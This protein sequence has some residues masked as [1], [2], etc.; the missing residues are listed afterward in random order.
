MREFIEM[1]KYNQNINFEKGLENRIDI[2]YVIERLEEIEKDNVSVYYKVAKDEVEMAIED[3]HNDELYCY[4][5]EL[6][7]QLDNINIDEIADKVYDDDDCW[8]DVYESARYYVLKE[9]ES[10]ED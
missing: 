10:E 2:D 6:M 4:D 1:L 5:E 9:I 7:K 8:R 3:I